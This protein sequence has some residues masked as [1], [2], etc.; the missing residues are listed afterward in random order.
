M[1]VLFKAFV[2]K[3]R[4]FLAVPG[5][6]H[7]DSSVAILTEHGDSYG[8]WMSIDSFKKS[9][10]WTD[11]NFERMCLGKARLSVQAI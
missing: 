1:V 8:S 10:D 9:Q 3:G 2:F 7:G 4:R 11:Y 6:H 5:S